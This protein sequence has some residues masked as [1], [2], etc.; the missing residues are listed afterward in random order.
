MK[1]N[2]YKYSLHN[3]NITYRDIK[4]ME[5]AYHVPFYIYSGRDACEN[6]A[7]VQRCLGSS[8]RLCYAVK[9]NYFLAESLIDVA[10]GFEICSRG[11]LDYCLENHVPA[12][13][14]S[15]S[16]VWKSEEDVRRA[17]KVGVR[18]FVLDSP[19]Q[20][21][22][23]QE[24]ADKK[25]KVLLRL[26]SGNQFGM[27]AHEIVKVLSDES[28]SS[29][30]EISGIHYYAGTQRQ[31]TY[32]LEQDFRLLTESLEQFENQGISI[33][34]LQIGGGLGVPLF[35]SDDIEECEKAADYLFSFIRNLAEYYQVTYECGRLI[36]ANAGR[37][38]AKVF[39]KKQRAGREILF[40]QGGSHHIR[41]HGNV[42]GQRTL[43]IDGVAKVKRQ[44]ER[45]Y[46]LCGSLCSSADIL[47]MKFK[48]CPMEI[49]D[50][51]LFYNAGAYALQEASNIFLGMA[52]PGILIYNKD[53][54]APKMLDLGWSYH[55]R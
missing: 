14:I 3:E 42:V 37:Y 29:D 50:Y 17:L 41:Y 36:A 7:E 2:F 44:G 26:S 33:K 1:Y 51:V 54:S 8:V 45:E 55:E 19:R 38:V 5:E 49:G 4:K 46:M 9:A 30:L 22:M 47:S 12:E 27:D 39:E 40:V 24:F 23:L 18:R 25:V 10:A 13:K 15:Y 34:E 53:N 35:E 6:A 20:L 16:G 48:H 43:F 52:M 32:Q 31:F 21:A 28:L 11:E